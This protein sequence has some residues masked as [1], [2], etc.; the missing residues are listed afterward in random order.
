MKT[1]VLVA[2]NW[3]DVVFE[4]RNKE[5]GAYDI[6]QSY[7]KSMMTGLGVSV[8]FACLLIVLP[9]IFALFGATAEPVIP[10]TKPIDYHDLTNPPI[11]EAIKPPPPPAPKP[12]QQE[13]SAAHMQVTDEETDTEVTPNEEIQVEQPAVDGV[14][15]GEVI[16]PPAEVVAPV[17]APPAPPTIFLTAE[18]MPKFDG[19]VDFLSRKLKYP[20]AARRMGISGKVYVGFVVDAEGNVTDVKLVRGI[21]PD[22]DKE[23]IRV[24]SMMPQWSPGMQNKRAVPVRMVIP[25]NFQLQQ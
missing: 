10:E 5:Y 3:D 17:E 18:V 16:A 25:I 14:G 15:N 2:K 22:C 19:M 7:N 12:P 9:K 1:E 11:I 20:G 24:V 6:R 4:N 8:S 13:A 21:H 23:A